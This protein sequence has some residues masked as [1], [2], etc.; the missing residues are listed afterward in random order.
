M[1]L[2]VVLAV[3]VG[4]FLSF[5]IAFSENYYAARV[6]RTLLDTAYAALV[7]GTFL[8][9]GFGVAAAVADR[10]ARRRSVTAA[11]TDTMEQPRSNSEDEE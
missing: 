5:G 3:V 4:F 8:S 10:R 11:P 1:L 6:D 7:A 9:P 2:L